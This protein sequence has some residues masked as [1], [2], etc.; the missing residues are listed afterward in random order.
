MSIVV[1]PPPPVRATVTPATELRVGVS[2]IIPAPVPRVETRVTPQ[3]ETQVTVPHNTTQGIPGPAGESAI[4]AVVG[5]AGIALS[6]HRA[7]LEQGGL[8]GYADNMIPEHA[9]IVLGITTRAT[10]AFDQ[11]TVTTFGKVTEPSWSWAPDLP[12]YLGSSGRL[13]QIP[14]I[15]GFRLIMG[16]ALSA[17]E[18]MVRLSE[19]IQL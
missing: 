10:N 8:L 13:T 9:L 2:P 14:P 7:V 12:I 11:A 1:I 4:G 16:M 5:I 17:T 15:T 3:A 18:M 6:G 19:P